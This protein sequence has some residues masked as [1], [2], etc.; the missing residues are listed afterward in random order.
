MSLH[1]WVESRSRELQTKEKRKATEMGQA[2]SAGSEPEVIDVTGEERW[3][4][5]AIGQ[6]TIRGVGKANPVVGEEADAKVPLVQ[7]MRRLI[8]SR[9]YSTG[10]GRRVVRGDGA[11]NG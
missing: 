1:E 4:Q 7:K 5:E 8:K 11:N 6:A 10:K 3:E 9:G 2:P